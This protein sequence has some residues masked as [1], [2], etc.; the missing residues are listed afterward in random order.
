MKKKETVKKSAVTDGWF[1]S[2]TDDCY[3]GIEK[4]FLE[5]DEQKTPWDHGPFET[6]AEAKK[7]A[8]LYYESRLDILNQ[9]VRQINL[10][11]ET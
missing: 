3:N 5:W 6:Q 1:W 9:I 4:G 10:T 7:S 2:G 11:K 8:L